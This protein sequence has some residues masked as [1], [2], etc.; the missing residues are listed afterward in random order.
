M[1]TVNDLDIEKFKE[2]VEANSEVEIDFNELTQNIKID[3]DGNIES[4]GSGMYVLMSPDYEMLEMAG[5]VSPE[6]MEKIISNN[7]ECEEA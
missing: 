2:E 4:T 5:G 3:K 1:K 7:D 6:A